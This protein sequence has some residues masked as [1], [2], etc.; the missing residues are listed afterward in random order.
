LTLNPDEVDLDV[1]ALDLESV[2]VGEVLDEYELLPA[3]ELVGV[4]FFIVGVNLNDTDLTQDGKYANVRCITVDNRKVCF[5]DGSTGVYTQLKRI[6][7]AQAATA[8]GPKP[9]R[10]RGGLR[11]S[12]FHVDRNGNIT[13]GTPNA[14]TYYLSS[15]LTASQKTKALLSMLQK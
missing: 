14:A 10:V 2:D 13:E 11:V 5:N 3:S 8:D 4:P 6:L 15:S 12:V 7:H 1:G 9:I